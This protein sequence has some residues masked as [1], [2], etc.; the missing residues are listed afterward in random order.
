MCI[1]D[2]GVDLA[3][4]VAHWDAAL[5]E[6]G[7]TVRAL[8]T[9]PRTGAVLVYVYRPGWLGQILADPE[10]GAF[11]EQEGYRPGDTEALLASCP[12][13]SA[14]KRTSPTRSGS[15]WAIRW[16]TWWA[17]SATGA[18]TIPIAGIGRLTAIPPG[19]SNVLPGTKNAKRF[20]SG[21]L[22]AAPR[23]GG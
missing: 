15:F 6:L 23:C 22:P 19:R 11:L 20:T 21:F 14:A 13:G 18:A 10:V 4:R 17:L 8:K 12:G 1:R 7:V 2:S 3:R 16:R 9:C 5:S